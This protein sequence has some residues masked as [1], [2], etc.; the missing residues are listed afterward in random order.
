MVIVGNVDE[1]KLVNIHLAQNKLKPAGPVASSYNCQ[2]FFRQQNSHKLPCGRKNCRI[3]APLETM[4]FG[5]CCKIPLESGHCSHGNSLT[6][7]LLAKNLDNIAR[8][9]MAPLETRKQQ[10]II[11]DGGTIKKNEIFDIFW[12]SAHW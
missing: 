3:K 12:K 11:D 7:G 1:E 2:Y 6:G 9:S 4:T 5:W 10:D 8:A